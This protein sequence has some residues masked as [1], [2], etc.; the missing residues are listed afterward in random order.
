MLLN[1]ILSV[2]LQLQDKVQNHINFEVNVGL[3]NPKTHGDYRRIWNYVRR[4]IT[5]VNRIYRSVHA[6]AQE[7]TDNERWQAEED[8]WTSTG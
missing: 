8:Q 1:R 7:I 6:E 5:R 4:P 3:R 2:A